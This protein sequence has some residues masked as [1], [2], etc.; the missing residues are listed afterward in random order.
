M[1]LTLVS[2]TF[3][4]L[5]AGCAR[6]A[7]RPG[8]PVPPSNDGELNKSVPNASP[9]TARGFTAHSWCIV[10]RGPA[11]QTFQYRRTYAAPPSEVFTVER[12]VV[13]DHARGELEDTASGIY[14]LNGNLLTENIGTRSTK[15][16]IE[17][18]D[19]VEVGER[20][21]VS[22]GGAHSVYDP[23]D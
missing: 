4:V 7:A 10:A 15:S 9:V 17:I 1:R 19:D 21:I 22:S 23:C 14:A 20:L 18:R 12:Y 3:A 6:H 8:K 11:D 2:L 16:T 5:A 13:N